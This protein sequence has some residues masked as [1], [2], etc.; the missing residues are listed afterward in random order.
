MNTGPNHDDNKI[1]VCLAADVLRYA[2]KHN[3]SE[4]STIKIYYPY[5]LNNTD[6]HDLSELEKE[7]QQLL[8]DS[9]AMVTEYFKKT[10][11]NVNLFYDIHRWS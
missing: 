4:D 1:F 2:Q 7:K 6:I 11:E 10:V 8:V 3:L 5:L 9:D